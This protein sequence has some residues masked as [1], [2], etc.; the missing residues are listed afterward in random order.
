MSLIWALFIQFY[1]EKD[2]VRVGNNKPGG[3]KPDL[4]FLSHIF[5][6]SYFSCVSHEGDMLDVPGH[7][8]IAHDAPCVSQGTGKAE[9]LLSFTASSESIL[10][11][12]VGMLGA[13]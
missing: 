11:K 7:M 3:E 4:F 8:G 9:W 12:N 5:P 13:S 10:S 2:L 6:V 1:A